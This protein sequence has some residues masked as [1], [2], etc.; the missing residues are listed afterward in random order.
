MI[1][2]IKLANYLFI[3]FFYYS[4]YLENFL[5]STINYFNFFYSIIQRLF[6]FIFVKS[7]IKKYKKR[8]KHNLQNKWEFFNAIYFV[9]LFI[10]FANLIFSIINFNLYTNSS[11]LYQQNKKKNSLI[12]YVSILIYTINY[13]F[14]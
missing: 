13:F 14:Y 11:S 7:K 2:T 4:N 6:Y 12:I 1:A 3:L 8:E 10:I 9:L 5:N